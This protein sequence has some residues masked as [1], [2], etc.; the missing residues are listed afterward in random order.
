MGYSQPALTVLMPVHN[1]ERY[2][3]EA[4]ASVLQQDFTDF[5]FVIVDDGSID[6]TAE[7]VRRWAERDSRIVIARLAE[8][9]GISRS[10]NRG[11]A[12]ARGRYV[13][14]QDADDISLSG[15]LRE[16]VKLL[17]QEPDV[18]MVATNYDLIEA[19][20][21]WFAR[22]MVCH[23]S[24]VTAY[25]L[26]FSNAVVGGGVMFRR[27]VV[28]DAGAYSE[29]FAPSEDYDLWGR[30]S[31]HGRIVTLPMI[32]MKI[33][34]HDERVSILH[35]ACQ[36]RRSRTIARKLLSEFLGRD[37]TDEEEDA[38]SSVWRA[39]G[40]VGLAPRAH[41]LLSEAH[42]RFMESK[43]NRPHG[44]RVRFETA[45]RWVLSAKTLAKNGALIEAA[46]HVA[47]GLRWHPLGVA[48]AVVFLAQRVA[49][50]FGRAIRKR[51]WQPNRDV[52]TA[53]PT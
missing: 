43:S 6:S 53:V 46:R 7:R 25:R 27:S 20:G 13:A 35:N 4:I 41:A 45:R 30:I 34:M 8:N 3:D 36:R 17:D 49:F 2:V 32:G 10:L 50:H 47:Y 23:P 16:Q 28:M 21:E 18:V 5:E 14:R 12:M 9:A 42:C 33:R 26:N 22:E 24:E 51:V 1:G 40:R 38:V 48:A 29:E 39:E 19:S 44:R 31:R 52:T 15:R 11:L 37:I